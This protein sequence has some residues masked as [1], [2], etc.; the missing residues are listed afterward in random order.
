M[1]AGSVVV[2]GPSVT[3]RPTGPK[4]RALGLN[5]NGWAEGLE[6][7]CVLRIN[8]WMRLLEAIANEMLCHRHCKKKIY[9]Y[10]VFTV[11]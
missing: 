11:F 8:V 9:I 7:F 2:P 3:E 5:S 10:I 1:F 4:S 6:A